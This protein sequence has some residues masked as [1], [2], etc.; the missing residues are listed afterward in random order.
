MKNLKILVFG[1]VFSVLF[2]AT[3]TSCENNDIRTNI[4]EDYVAEN[5]KFIDNV[6]DPNERFT[7]TI[8][9]SVDWGRPKRGCSGFG[10]CGI[11]IDISGIANPGTTTTSLLYDARTDSYYADLILAEALPE[12]DVPL[13]IEKSISIDTEERLGK[14][15]VAPQGEYKFDASL[16]RNGGYRVYFK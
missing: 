15:L 4:T 10:I 6:S 12:N 16:G 8:T 9:I 14:T 1:A 7:I 3:F 5:A 2:L 13:V 11:D